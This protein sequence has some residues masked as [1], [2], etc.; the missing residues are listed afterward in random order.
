M[1]G[2]P[3]GGSGSVSAGQPW[4]S[5]SDLALQEVDHTL[6]L[7]ARFTQLLDMLLGDVFFTLQRSLEELKAGLRGVRQLSLAPL[8]LALEVFNQVHWHAP[9]AGDATPPA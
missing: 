8:F 1:S 2:A 5:R 3:S 4:G 9:P 6:I 7:I